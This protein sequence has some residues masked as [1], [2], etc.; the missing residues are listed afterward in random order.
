[1]TNAELFKLADKASSAKPLA[2]NALE[3][4]IMA[5]QL[6]EVEKLV[7]DAKTAKIQRDALLVLMDML[8]N[9]VNGEL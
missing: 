6:G 1:M 4:I 2:W 5:M 8:D 7:F 3:D 9:K